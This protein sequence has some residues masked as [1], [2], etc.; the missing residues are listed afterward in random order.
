MTLDVVIVGAGPNG[1]LLACELRL[2]GVPVLLL[3]RSPGL[4]GEP[5]ANGLMGRVVQAMDLRGLYEPLAG[6]PGPPAPTPWFQYGGL[7]LD[8]SGVADNPLFALPVPQARIQQV[9]AERARALGAE[10]RYGH[11][12][13]GFAQGDDG[14]VIT[15]RA[16]DGDQRL[17]TRW[18]VGADGGHSLVRKHAGIDFRGGADD[19]FV[20]HLGHAVIP[21]DRL[22]PDGTLALPDGRR[23]WP[24]AH[25]R[26]PGGV[27]TFARLGDTGAAH[28]VAAMEWTGPRPDDAPVT[29][30]D[31]RDAVDRV[32]DVTLSLGPPTGAAPLLR[33]LSG[34][35]LRQAASY[36]AGRVLLLGD[37]AHVHP[38]VGG[39]GLNLG[40]QDAL[41][42]GWKLAAEVRG[43]AP[44]GLLD[45]YQAERAPVGR[46]VALQSR[47]QLAL[48]APGDD[49]T[50]VRELL[51][52]LLRQEHTRR[53]VAA[54][55]AGADQPYDM[56]QPDPHPA[57][58]AWL[59]DLLPTL[60]RGRA[61]VLDRIRAARPVV[62]ELVDGAAAVT[63]GWRDRVDVVPARG[64]PDATALL[65]RPDGHLAWA[66]DTADGL[67]G[68]LRR[69]FGS[70]R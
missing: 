11:E 47:A 36:R 14:V 48:L 29:F 63:A 33:R 56:G 20:S 21:A 41:N 59:P 51:A 4:G 57:T 62:V 45:T 15:V 13:I 31:L 18:L 65:V 23:L 70:P 42:L 22:G 10:I 60:A 7:P 58:G 19:R 49:V 26:L 44:P 9:L 37:A 40:L 64:G 69:W 35:N 52:E 54:L 12:V 5:R 6:R 16:P 25:H 24:F 3:E 55:L 39:P 1:L 27:F 66:G 34:V 68:A 50:A 53:D 43:W 61:A 28:L 17:R 67:A 30:A 46:R 8:L 32:L 2:A 38:A